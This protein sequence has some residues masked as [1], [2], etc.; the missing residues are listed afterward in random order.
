MSAQQVAAIGC[1][2][3]D[4]RAGDTVDMLIG[5][6]NIEGGPRFFEYDHTNYRAMAGVRGDLDDAWSYDSYALVLRHG[7]VQLG[8][9]ATFRRSARCWG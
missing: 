4:D 9:T 3:G 5:R 7:P 6:R 8:T 2:C 1:D